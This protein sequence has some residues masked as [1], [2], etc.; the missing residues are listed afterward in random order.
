MMVETALNGRAL[1][2][3]ELT[4]LAVSE[5]CSGDVVLGAEEVTVV[6]REG[7]QPIIVIDE[8][9]LRGGKIGERFALADVLREGV[10]GTLAALVHIGIAELG[11]EA[12]GTIEP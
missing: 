9:E 4:L 6:E 5:K 2:D 1:V 3:G 11:G 8:H 7:E 10:E 12:A